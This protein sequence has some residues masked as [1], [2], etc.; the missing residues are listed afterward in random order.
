MDKISLLKG[1]EALFDETPL[2]TGR[3][4]VII[5]KDNEGLVIGTPNGNKKLP[6]QKDIDSINSQL[7]GI[8]SEQTTQNAN[9]ATNTSQLPKFSK[10]QIEDGSKVHSGGNT[11]SAFASG[12]C[13]K[14]KEKYALRNGSAHGSD[15]GKIIAYICLSVKLT[16][17]VFC[18]KPPIKSESGLKNPLFLLI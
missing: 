15:D 16:P 7:E 3:P 11:Y 13:F 12:V 18:S 1:T 2:P 5:D 9:I 4:G 10:M 8:I 14:G 6:R 17:S